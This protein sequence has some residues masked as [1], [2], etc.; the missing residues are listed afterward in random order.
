MK[1]RLSLQN[2]LEELLGARR[3]YFQPPESIKMSYPCFVYY[4]NDINTQFANNRAYI[5][6]RSY[7]ITYID[8]NPDADMPDRMLEHFPQCTLDR[9]YSAQGL[10]HFVFDLIY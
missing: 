7:T 1:T 4:L 8:K 3:V 5:N 2:E 9:T 6:K 10:H